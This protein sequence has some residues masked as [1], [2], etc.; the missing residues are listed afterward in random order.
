VNPKNICLRR[1][2]PG[3]RKGVISSDFLIP[4]GKWRGNRK[5]VWHVLF[6]RA[7]ERWVGENSLHHRGTEGR[8]ETAGEDDL[9]PSVVLVAADGFARPAEAGTTNG[10]RAGFRRFVVPPSGGKTKTRR[11]GFCCGWQAGSP[12]TVR[13][14]RIPK[15]LSRQGGASPPSR[16]GVRFRFPVPDSM[17]PA[18]RR[19]Q[20]RG[21]NPVNP[22]KSC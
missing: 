16:L 17:D 3:N 14:T 18:A 20:G 8:R 13:P 21:F 2:P 11:K 9:K 12:G 6:R 10:G 1:G 7:P 22:G 5:M 4:G 19:R 15:G